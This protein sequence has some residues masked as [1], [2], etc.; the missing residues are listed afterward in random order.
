[1][2]KTIHFVRM[3]YTSLC[4]FISTHSIHKN[5]TICLLFSHLCVRKRNATDSGKYT[6]THTDARVYQRKCHHTNANISHLKSIFFFFLI[7]WYARS[8]GAESPPFWVLRKTIRS[9][10]MKFTRMKN[11]CNKFI[12]LNFYFNCSKLCCSVQL[13]AMH[14]EFWWMW[15]D[16]QWFSIHFSRIESVVKRKQRVIRDIHT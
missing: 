7:R 1:M 15:I 9:M 5:E 6:H 11:R 14:I 3:Y 16:F 2:T 12:R 8:T 4:T 10:W 13:E